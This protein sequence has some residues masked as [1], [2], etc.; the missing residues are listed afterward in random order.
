[1]KVYKEGK[2]INP[3]SLYP[4][5]IIINILEQFLVDFFLYEYCWPLNSVGVR[6]FDCLQVQ[7]FMY[8]L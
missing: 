4:E 1:M 8:N 6:A 7:N 5:K 2:W 3:S